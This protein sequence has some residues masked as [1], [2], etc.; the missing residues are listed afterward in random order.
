MGRNYFKRSI[1]GTK[2]FFN[3]N[4]NTKFN[5]LKRIAL[6]FKHNQMH[7]YIVLG[8]DMLVVIF[9]CCLIPTAKVFLFP[10][11]DFDLSKFSGQLFLI[12]TV[13]LICYVIFKPYLGVVRYSGNV[14]TVK[15]I[16]SVST[17]T[18]ILIANNIIVEHIRCDFTEACYKRILCGCCVYIDI[19]ICLLHPL[20]SLY[21][22]S[23]LFIYDQ[24]RG[25]IFKS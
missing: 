21:E 5:I 12:F 16:I 15:L 1:N 10:N 19:F 18:L 20:T 7:P 17:A 4:M 9:C 2:R 25:L 8:V 23:A 22:C 14:D 6:W 11:F 13:Y 3:G 24:F